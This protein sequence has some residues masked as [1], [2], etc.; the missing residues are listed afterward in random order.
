M[1]KLP[2]YQS[3]KV[4]VAVSCVQS[5][6]SLEAETPAFF[7]SAWSKHVLTASHS[8]LKHLQ[9]GADEDIKKTHPKH[10]RQPAV[11][12]FIV[13]SCFTL[14][15][16]QQWQPFLAAQ[17]KRSWLHTVHL[18]KITA[19]KSSHS[20]SQATYSNYCGTF[21]SCTS[22]ACCINTCMGIWTR[23]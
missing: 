17:Q 1:A 11:K 10:L 13:I 4:T 6:I 9:L 12:K 21:C 15:K 18:A 3:L 20:A 19:I 14:L 8:I 22:A 7:F 16:R 2:T 5:A 23:T